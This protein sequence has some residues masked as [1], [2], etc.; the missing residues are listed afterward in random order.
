VKSFR[1]AWTDLEDWILAGRIKWKE[2]I[3]D[4]IEHL[5]GAFIGLFHG[6]NFGRRLVRV[7][8]VL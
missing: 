4:G 1:R 3:I 6:D 7:G 8:D 5:P 2:E